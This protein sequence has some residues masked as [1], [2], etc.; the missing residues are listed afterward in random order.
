[1]VHGSKPFFDGAE[2]NFGGKR[3]SCKMRQP[4]ILESEQYDLNDVI[5]AVC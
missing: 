4:F 3:V 5:P 1:M 2:L